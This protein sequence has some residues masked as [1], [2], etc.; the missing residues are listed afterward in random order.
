MNVL[1]FDLEPVSKIGFVS[2]VIL[3]EAKNLAVCGSF[4]TLRSAQGD[5]I[6]SF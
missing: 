5:T 2:V 4:E 6:V 1:W 3:S